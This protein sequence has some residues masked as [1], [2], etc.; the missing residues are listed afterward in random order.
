M[1]TGLLLGDPL[2]AVV[3][4]HEA[5]ALLHHPAYAGAAGR[6]DDVGDAGRAQPVVVPPGAG[7]QGAVP[8]R[9]VAGEVDH[10]L[11]ADVRRVEAVDVEH[12]TAHRASAQ[13]GHSLVRGG[14][15]GHHDHVVPGVDQ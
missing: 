12:V 9:D 8:D 10:D 13:T 1:S 3:G 5:D 2:V 11:G 14:G 6:L 4:V 15:A 7:Q